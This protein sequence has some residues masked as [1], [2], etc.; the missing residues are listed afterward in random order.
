MAGRKREQYF[1][2][3]RAGMDRDYDPMAK[4]FSAVV[5]RTLETYARP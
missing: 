1:A 4:I 5:R 2:A 3:V